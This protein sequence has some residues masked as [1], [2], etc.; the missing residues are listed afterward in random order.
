VGATT[1][2]V[3]SIAGSALNNAIYLTSLTIPNSVTTIGSGA[4]SYCWSLPNITL[5]ASVTSIGTGAFANCGAM[6]AITVEPANP[7]YSSLNGVL[8]DKT[9]A[10]LIRFPGGG[11]SEYAVPAGVTHIGAT[12]FSSNS[13]LTKVTL[14]ASVSQIGDFAF[15]PCRSL[16]AFEVEDANATYASL[17]GVLFDK[18]LTTLV[19]CP[20]GKVGYYQIPAS[21]TSLVPSAFDHCPWLTGVTIP[22][23]ITRIQ[24]GVFLGCERLTSMVIPNSVTGIGSSAFAGCFELVSVKIPD[25][26]TIIER[27]A[28]QSCR[29]LTSITIP[30]SVTSIGDSA[31]AYC[32]SLGNA[33]FTGNAPVMNSS[34]FFSIGSGLTISFQSGRTGFTTPT[35]LGVST[36]IADPAQMP[37]VATVSA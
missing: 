9:R 31:F 24:D 16:A 37:A 5:P 14:P 19:Q 12:A 36:V 21:V 8:F 11:A 22:D 25:S 10:T 18:S 30:A 17:D 28:F 7:A 13:N 20:S 27:Q 35:W 26:V 1:Y 2:P 4:F 3:T 32:T 6:T 33:L 15:S 29:N 34:A 23:G